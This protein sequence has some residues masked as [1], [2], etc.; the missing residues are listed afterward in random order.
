MTATEKMIFLALLYA[1]LSLNRIIENLKTD[2]V[3]TGASVASRG[4]IDLGVWSAKLFSMKSERV[5]NNSQD[6]RLSVTLG[7]ILTLSES[8]FLHL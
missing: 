4:A 3:A 5:R 1:A 2:L 8:Q 6:G 7:K